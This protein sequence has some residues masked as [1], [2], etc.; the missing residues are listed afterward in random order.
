MNKSTISLIIIILAAFII[1]PVQAQV[2]V[3]QSGLQFLKVDVGA[4]AAAMAGAF[5]EMSGD[6][7]VMFY[8][9]SGI[10]EIES[11]IDVFAGQTMW[12]A[13]IKYNTAAVVKNLGGKWGSIGI[14]LIYADY[15]DDIIETQFTTANTAG[16]IETGRTVGIGAY[17][18]GLNY[19]RKL[20]EKFFVGA[21]ARY[22]AQWLGY[23]TMND[24]SRKKNE[25]SGLSFDF[26]TTFYP[27][28]KSFKFGM[29]I[30]NFSKEYKYEKESFN[31]PLTFT[32][33]VA[34]D[35]MDFT[36]QEDHSLWIAVDAIHPRDYSERMHLGTEYWYMGM[37]AVRAGYKFNYDEEG[38]SAGVGFKYN[39]SGLDMRLDYAYTDFG[40][41]DPVNRISVGFAF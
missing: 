2:K 22:V 4:R 12:I 28:F 29:S 34:M 18:A 33:G 9:P 38:I 30:R 10:A 21:Q 5:T 17:A 7:T 15:G 1:L 31:L 27:G 20:T 23:S 26:G 41:F 3:A 8:N 37:F 11:N 16:Y 25:V 32:I 14:G 19:A 36:D 40:V 6:A 13:D 39:V 24:N 35:M